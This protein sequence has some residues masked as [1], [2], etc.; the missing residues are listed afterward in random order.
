MSKVVF[1]REFPSKKRGEPLSR[2]IFQ[3]TIFFFVKWRA[4]NFVCRLTLSQNLFHIGYGFLK[5]IPFPMPLPLILL[6][7]NV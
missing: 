5:I 3:D 4:E 7:K 2:H 1:G 6:E